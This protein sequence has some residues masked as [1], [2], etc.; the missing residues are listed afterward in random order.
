VSASLRPL[1][2]LVT[3]EFKEKL[4]GWD[5][6]SSHDRTSGEGGTVWAV[7]ISVQGLVWYHNKAVLTEAGLD[8]ERAPQ[9]WG[10]FLAACDAVKRIGKAG[11]AAG[12]KEGF[13]GEWFYSSASLQA[14]A[15]GD[16]A[17]LKTGERKWTDPELV[18]VLSRLKELSDR[19]CFQK[20]VMSTPL[21]PDAGEV[22]MRGEAAFFLGLIS[23]VGHW[24][25]FGEFLGPENVGVTTCPV[26][27]PGPGAGT[28]PVGGIAYA[29]TAWAEHPAEAFEYI[30]FIADDEHARTFLTDV[31][32]FPANQRYDRSVITDPCARLLSEWL[33]EGRGVSRVGPPARVEEAIRRECQRL[34]SGQ[35][36]VAGALAA[37]ERAAASARG[38]EKER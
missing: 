27:R 35:T 18:E 2:D 19:G 37:V 17:R 38:E 12:Q 5:L 16:A 30:A 7:P 10:E 23:D 1:T 24:K 36:D 34:M 31:G 22:F 21:F 4:V 11:V 28:F 3:P 32:S 8:P 29:V 15:P 25:D 26:F 20:G 33:E 14:L 6:C 13:W 9:T